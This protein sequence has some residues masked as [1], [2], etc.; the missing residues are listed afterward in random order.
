MV[1]PSQYDLHHHP[2]YPQP[3]FSKVLVQKRL[4]E[5]VYSVSAILSGCQVCHA[6]CYAH[7]VLQGLTVGDC[8]CLHFFQDPSVV[9]VNG[10]SVGV[11]STDTLKHLAGQTW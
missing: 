6:T 5:K 8:S 4:L 10:V 3:P 2:V 9:D 11:T 7:P 1:L